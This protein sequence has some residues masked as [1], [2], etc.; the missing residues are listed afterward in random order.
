MTHTT[1]FPR[2]FV[3]GATLCAHKVEGADFA[4]D[5][6]NWEQRPGRIA[7]G[8]TSETAAGHYDRWREDAALAAKLGLNALLVGPSWARIQPAAG[9]FDTHALDHYEA[10]FRALQEHGVA[11]VCA[12]WAVGAPAWFTRGGGWRRP[13]APG[14]F[15]AYA[16]RV[17]RRLGPWCRHWIPLFEPERWLSA[18]CLEGRWPGG[19]GLAAYFQASKHLVRAHAGAACAVRAVQPEAR[20]GAA[21]RGVCCR[22]ENRYSSWDLRGARHEM[23]RFHHRFLAK[24]TAAKNSGA[25]PDFI[26]VGYYGRG[27]VRFAPLHMRRLCVCWVD[28][29]GTVRPAAHTEPYAAGLGPVLDDFTRYHLPLYVTG[30]GLPTEDDTARRHYLL[31]HVDRLHDAIARGVP[32]AGYFHRALLDGFEWARGF[33]PRYGLVHVDRRTFARTPN[34]SAF[35]LKE[36]CR[37]GGVRPGALK[38]FAPG[39]RPPAP[40]RGEAEP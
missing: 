35:L 30:N 26:G 33:G 17:A 18:A 14:L 11:P 3:W 8:A 5:W 36:I 27:R 34:E 22:P 1:A 2:D 37:A 32:V 24:I 7:G 13:E 28:A 15:A 19:R 29:A 21:V 38:R 10:F 16:D 39:W 23:A 9:E 6:W 4:S 40:G 25:A 31:D 20:V 12:L